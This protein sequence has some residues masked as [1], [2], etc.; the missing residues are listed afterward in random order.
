MEEGELLRLKAEEHIREEEE[1]EKEKRSKNMQN[2]KDI[3][4]INE[5][6]KELKAKQAAKEKSRNWRSM[7]IAKSK[8]FLHSYRARS[9][10]DEEEA[11]RP[12]KLKD[13]TARIAL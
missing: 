10:S 4:V 1:K 2:R 5:K 12:H 6:N 7:N 9:R 8:V 13:F 11:A 3:N